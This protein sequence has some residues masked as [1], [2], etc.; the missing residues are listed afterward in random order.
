M[1]NRARVVMGIGVNL[2][3]ARWP[4]ALAARAG[5]VEGVTGTRLNPDDV[6]IQLLATLS[7]RCDDLESG[8]IADLLRRWELLA[9]SSR[10]TTV[11]WSV[12]ATRRRGITE[13]LNED[14]ALIVRVGTDH[15]CLVGGE[16]R[17]VRTRSE[18]R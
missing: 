18:T 17:H 14:G 15:E 5:S 1:G 7:E 12:G 9:P 11:E 16:V 10:G 3:E 13:G 6:L 2:R 8:S 4:G